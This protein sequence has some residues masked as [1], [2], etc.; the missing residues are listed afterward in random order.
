[1]K[2][3]IGDLLSICKLCENSDGK[4]ILLLWAQLKLHLFMYHGTV[5]YFDGKEHLLK[6]LSCVID[7][8]NGN[9]AFY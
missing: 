2:F 1:V 9:F 3:H 8:P 6:S 5:S 7:Y 4:V